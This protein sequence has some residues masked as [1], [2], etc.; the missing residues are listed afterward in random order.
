MNYTFTI[1]FPPSVNSYWRHPS[2]GRLAGRTLISEAGRRYRDAIM[3]QSVAE[4]WP[5]FGVSRL[6]VDI[7]AWMPD[8]RRRDLDNVLKAAL[9][10]MTHAMLWKDDS[11]IDELSVKRVPTMG[12][13]LKVKVEA[14]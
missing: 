4:K 9:D 6:R 12:G 8:R 10:S 7:E 5:N 2:T 14:L 3:A 13:M 1:P 11:Q